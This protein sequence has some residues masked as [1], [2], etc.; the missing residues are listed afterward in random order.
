MLSFAKRDTQMP[1]QLSNKTFV[2]GGLLQT[3]IN[4]KQTQHVLLR[5]SFLDFVC[6]CNSS[7]HEALFGDSLQR[8][9]LTGQALLNYLNLPFNVPWLKMIDTRVTVDGGWREKEL[10]IT[11]KADFLSVFY[12]VPKKGA[13]KVNKKQVTVPPAQLI[14]QNQRSPIR[15]YGRGGLVQAQVQD[16][17]FIVRVIYSVVLVQLR[18]QLIY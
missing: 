6:I 7:Q 12:L 10:S 17:L 8:N 9:E 3:V 15:H 13:E 1:E 14:L 18:K 11:K 5:A 16:Y 4:L 2:S